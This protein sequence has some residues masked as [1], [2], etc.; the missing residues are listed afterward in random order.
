MYDTNNIKFND[1][2][3]MEDL[4]LNKAISSLIVKALNKSKTKV[5]A[6]DKLGIS[7]NG[8]WRSIS[9]YNIIDNGKEYTIK[10]TAST[11]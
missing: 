10:S 4:N 1:R 7:H 11:R 3:S 8:L 2:F 9:K 5:E 6:C